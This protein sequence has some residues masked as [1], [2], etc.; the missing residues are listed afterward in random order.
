MHLAEV[1]DLRAALQRA[2]PGWCAH[3][4]GAAGRPR[5]PEGDSCSTYGS[6][7]SE[8]GTGPG[9]HRPGPSRPAGDREGDCTGNRPTWGSA[10]QCQSHPEGAPCPGPV[11]LSEPHGLVGAHGEAGAAPQHPSGAPDNSTQWTDGAAIEVGDEGVA[12]RHRPRRVR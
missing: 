3:R 2:G 5:H 12:S 6:P 7:S 1:R 8:I 10:G 9:G 11:R 4:R